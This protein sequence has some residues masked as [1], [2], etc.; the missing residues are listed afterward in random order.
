MK[1]RFLLFCVLHACSAQIF[2][3]NLSCEFVGGTVVKSLNELPSEVQGLL[4][5]SERGINGISDIG[6]KF[7]SSDV[8]SDSTIPMQR[9]VSGTVGLNCIRLIVEH[10]GS[11]YGK[12]QLDLERFELGW[13]QVK[14]I[15]VTGREPWS[16][17]LAK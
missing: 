8:I 12:T 1:L 2:A 11:G 3:Q 9:L 4:G 5:R 13:V 14:S 15:A 17:R 10:G 6:E 16:A 7:N